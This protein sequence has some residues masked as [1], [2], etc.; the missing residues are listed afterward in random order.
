MSA[1]LSPISLSHQLLRLSDYD[2]SESQE[3]ADYQFTVTAYNWA[4]AYLV[5]MSIDL[6]YMTTSSTWLRKSG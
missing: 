2:S 5:S 4:I 6:V 3:E 1:D